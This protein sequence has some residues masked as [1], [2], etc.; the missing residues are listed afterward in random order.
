MHLCSWD[1]CNAWCSCVSK[2]WP[3]TKWLRKRTAMWN[4]KLHSKEW[5]P[6][7]WNFFRVPILIVWDFGWCPNVYRKILCQME[8]TFV[9][10]GNIFFIELKLNLREGDLLGWI[11]FWR[12]WSIK[13]SQA[14]Q[15]IS[16]RAQ[17]QIL[18]SNSVE[19]IWV[20]ALGLESWPSQV[21]QDRR[22]VLRHLICWSS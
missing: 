16:L 4:P 19:E 12:S 7:L 6:C 10:N 9:S 14:L 5:C 17:S 1:V 20:S 13:A 2:P 21:L 8:N 3:I 22:D 18:V 11:D 15:W